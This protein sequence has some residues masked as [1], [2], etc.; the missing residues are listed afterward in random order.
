MEVKDFVESHLD[1]H[2]RLIYDALRVT[3]EDNLKDRIGHRMLSDL[4]AT[5]RQV[6]RSSAPA[7]Q[8]AEMT[9]K[10]LR[11]RKQR[12]LRERQEIGFLQ[13]DAQSSHD[14][15][16]ESQDDQPPFDM[17]IYLFNIAEQRIDAEISR[18]GRLIR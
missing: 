4:T 16:E 15:A 3:E 10:A 8:E 2:L 18:Q 9:E 14:S 5:M 17:R 1:P 12:L 7:N 13:A 11:L 6:W